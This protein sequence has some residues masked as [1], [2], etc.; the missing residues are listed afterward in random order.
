MRRIVFSIVF[1]LSLSMTLFAQTTGKITGK[2]KDAATGEALI[3]V[4][5]VLDGT[6]LG[7]ASDVDGSFFILN[8]PPGKYNMKFMLIGYTTKVVEGVSV[9]VNRT[10]PID[11]TLAATT[12]D[13][14]EEVVVTA[15]RVT[16]KKDQ[17]SSIRNVTS[18]EMDIL[19]MESTSAVVALQP[20]VVQGHFRGGR[21]NETNVM[22]DGVSVQSGLDRGSMISVDPDAVQE[23]EVITGTFSAKYGEAMS[24]VV[25]MVTK[26]GGDRFSGKIEGYLGNYLTQHND[27][28]IGLKASEL[29]RNE[30]YKFMFEGPIIRN[31]LSFFVSGRV[32]DND[33]Y[34]NG[35]RRF[36]I[37]DEPDY[38]RFLDPTFFDPVT[39][40][41]LLNEHSGDS[42]YVPM[43]WSESIN[44]NGKLTYRMQNIKAS[45]MYLLN[46]GQGQGYS[47]SRMYKPDGRSRWHD[48]TDMLTLQLNHVLGQRLFYELKFSYTDSKTGSY[49]YADP[50]DSRYL[51]DRYAANESFTGFITGGQDKGHYTNSTTKTLGRLDLTWQATNNHS[52]DFGAEAF[53]FEYNQASYSILNAYRNT[54]AS[55]FLYAPE[56]MPDSSVYSDVYIK[57]PVQASAW[58][59]DKMEFDA[60]VVELGVRAEY[61]DPKTIYPTNYRN[62]NNLLQKEDTPEW[63]SQYPAADAKINVAPR[64]GLS[65]QL[66]EAALLRFSYGHF[67]QYPPHSTMYQNNSYVLSPT[68]YS[69]TLGNPQVE[70]EMT[71]N[72][73]IGLWQMLNRWMDLEVA[74]WYKDIYNLSTVNIQTTYNA[75]RYG[76]Y[77]NKDYGNAR[78]LELKYKAHVESFFAELNYTLQYTRGNADNPQF[79][80]NRAGNS[81]DP[82]PTLIPMSWDQRH[83]ANMTLGYNKDRW[84]ATMT[85]WMGSGSAFTWSPIDQNPLNRVNLYPN[86]SHKPFHY[87]ID[88]KANY[89]L[90]LRQRYSLRFTLYV[91]NLFDRLNEDNVNSN[92]GRTNQA[93]IRPQDRLGYWSDFSTY[94]QSIYSPSNWSSPRLVKL[95]VGLFF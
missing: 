41:Y 12:L 17:T 11:I 90:P 28:Y 81:Q 76:L 65:Y 93:I 31:R 33:G 52:L 10:T 47:H 29:D 66:G 67:Y 54:Q 45:L 24:G 79:T 94:E 2:I 37:T 55:A 18:E 32:Q 87:S 63:I 23:V 3:G 26:E 92:T 9:S 40:E 25:N 61:F 38:S 15:D 69:S 57:K 1:L 6:Y 89:D 19:P 35:I 70:P 58:L 71:V 48:K 42:T 27:V 53:R 44:L 64:L 73:E 16:V 82:I 86:N 4:N 88:L 72:Y 68:N 46:D 83:T 77:G 56:I 91:Y 20:G 49:L 85:G 13:L 78:G 8:I 84:G 75:L 51:H 62:P 60:M 22:I 34:L 7:A 43:S 14:G 36:N 50:F 21:S 39:G 80:F 30:D 59:T 5:V 95:G 74:L